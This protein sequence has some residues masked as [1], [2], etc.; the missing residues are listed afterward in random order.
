M[1]FVPI[2]KNRFALKVTNKTRKRFFRLKYEF[3]FKNADELINFLIDKIEL[4]V[5]NNH[6][7]QITKLDP[8][9]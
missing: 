9:K 7:V 2:P 1:P 8:Q 5:L 4:G 3:D 6:V